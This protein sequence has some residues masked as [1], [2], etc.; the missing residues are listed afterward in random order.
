LG[1]VSISV[2]N[3]GKARRNWQIS[4]KRAYL[5]EGQRHFLPKGTFLR[6]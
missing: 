4:S 5:R 3:V 6:G 1:Y 2:K